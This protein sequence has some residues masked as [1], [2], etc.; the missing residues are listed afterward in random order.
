MAVVDSLS[1]KQKAELV[2]DPDSGALEDEALVREVFASLT[3]S[4]DDGQLN[5]FFLAFANISKQVKQV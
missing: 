4:R 1:A 2:L 5:R 3:E